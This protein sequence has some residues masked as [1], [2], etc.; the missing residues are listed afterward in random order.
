[1]IMPERP[2]EQTDRNRSL[3]VMG[4]LCRWLSDI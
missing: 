3:A 1:M 2:F 4:R